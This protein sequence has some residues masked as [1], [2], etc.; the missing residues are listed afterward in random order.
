MLSMLLVLIHL[1]HLESFGIPY[2]MPFIG[3]DL[4]EYQDQRDTLLRMP[5]AMLWRRPIYTR[6]N[7]RRKLRWKKEKE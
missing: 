6:D 1:S 7:A 2:L 5:L 4:N 3:P